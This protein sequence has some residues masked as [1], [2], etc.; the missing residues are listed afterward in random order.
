MGEQGFEAKHL[1]PE[2]VLLKSCSLGPNVS[3]AS[4]VKHTLTAQPAL[5]SPRFS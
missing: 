5:S 3:L 2:A 4:S 1:A